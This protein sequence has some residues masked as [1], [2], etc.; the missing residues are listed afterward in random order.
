[1]NQAG[2][3]RAFSTLIRRRDRWEC[4]RCHRGFRMNDPFLQCAHMFGRGKPATRFDPENAC[5][6]CSP[7][8]HDYLDQHPNEKRMFF[9]LRLGDE[10][11]EA[12]ERRSNAASS[13]LEGVE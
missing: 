7:G 11:F 3:D 4:Q 2:M 10:A 13:R 6:L 12:L 8:C 9:R 5:A 1:M